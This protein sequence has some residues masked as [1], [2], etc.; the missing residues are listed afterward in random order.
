[1]MVRGMMV[2]V[3]VVMVL[4]VV[5]GIRRR[6]HRRREATVLLRQVLLQQDVERNRHLLPDKAETYDKPNPRAVR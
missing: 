6:D 5:I 4:P 3:A 2:M 1:M